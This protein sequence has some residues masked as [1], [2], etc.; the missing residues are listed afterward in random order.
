M[1][2][3]KR[4]V[5]H[6]N[7]NN[8]VLSFMRLDASGLT[9]REALVLYVIIKRPGIAGA[10][11]ASA[12]ALNSRSRIQYILERLERN[13]HIENRQQHRKRGVPGIFHATTKGRLLWAEIMGEKESWEP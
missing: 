4:S 5:A 2:L 12:L 11:I 1:L 6:A 9:V 10:D 8:V 13:K 7:D 3:S